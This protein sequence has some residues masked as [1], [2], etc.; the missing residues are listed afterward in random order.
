MATPICGVQVLA[1]CSTVQCVGTHMARQG[2]LTYPSCA[3]AL[4]LG[5]WRGR[6]QHG[7][8]HVSS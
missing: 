8:L 1:V 7:G 5:D 4:Q 3:V 6:G 2:R